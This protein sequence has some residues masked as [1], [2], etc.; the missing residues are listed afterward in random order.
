M[1][2]PMLPERMTHPDGS[3]KEQIGA[4]STVAGSCGGRGGSSWLV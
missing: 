4:I 1:I 2:H 3:H